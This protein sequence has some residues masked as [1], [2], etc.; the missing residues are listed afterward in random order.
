[1]NHR[2]LSPVAESLRQQIKNM[3]TEAT[4]K[5]PKSQYNKTT[6]FEEDANG[7]KVYDGILLDKKVSELIKQMDLGEVRRYTHL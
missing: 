4:P 1:M 6:V 7:N 2:P 3:I 5:P